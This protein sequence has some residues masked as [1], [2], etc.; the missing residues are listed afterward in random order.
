MLWSCTSQNT[1]PG[2][3]ICLL[4]GEIEGV[5]AAWKLSAMAWYYGGI[6]KSCRKASDNL[7]LG[8]HTEDKCLGNMISQ[9]MAVCVC[10]RLKD[11]M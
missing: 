10:D 7:L 1:E 2:S 5:A 3:S 8:S 11:G 6:Y 4:A 9:L